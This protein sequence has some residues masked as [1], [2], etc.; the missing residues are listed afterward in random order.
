MTLISSTIQLTQP[1]TTWFRGSRSEDHQHEAIGNC[2]L[3][4]DINLEC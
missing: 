1:F 4:N 3:L 2:P